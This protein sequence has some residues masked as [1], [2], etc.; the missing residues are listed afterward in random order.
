MPCLWLITDFAEYAMM[1][2]HKLFDEEWEDTLEHFGMPRCDMWPEKGIRPVWWPVELAGNWPYDRSVREQ[3]EVLMAL[4]PL[5]LK[6]D[7]L[8][9]DPAP[10]PTIWRRLGPKGDV[11]IPGRP[12][13]HMTQMSEWDMALDAGMRKTRRPDNLQEEDEDGNEDREIGKAGDT[14]DSGKGKRKGKRP[15]RERALKRTAH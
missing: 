13:H 10:K 2:P 4:D 5:A 11:Q 7:S 12:P 1:T 15:A 9:L 8:S 14:Q 6:A 3:Y